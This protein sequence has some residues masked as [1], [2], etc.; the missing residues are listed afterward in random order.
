MSDVTITPVQTSNGW[1]VCQHNS[2]GTDLFV[3]PEVFEP[4]YTQEHARL[5]AETLKHHLEKGGAT[6]AKPLPSGVRVLH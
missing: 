3:I 5:E 6:Y 4:Q 2:D 1:A